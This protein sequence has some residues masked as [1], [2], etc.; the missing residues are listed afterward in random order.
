M[1]KTHVRIADEACRRSVADPIEL[2]GKRWSA[3][4]L[5]ATKLGAERF[6]DYRTMVPGISDRLLSQRLK[7]L[8]AEHLMIR[9]V[10]P[11]TPV[12]IQY[13]LTQRAFE[14][15]DALQPL[16][17]WGN[18]WTPHDECTTPSRRSPAPVRSST[19]V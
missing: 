5:L 10:T 14:L 12:Q 16:V 18:K 17:A 9:E 2:V 13:R 6:G 15:V 3:A 7:E 19:G 4:I 8:E 1:H 11:S